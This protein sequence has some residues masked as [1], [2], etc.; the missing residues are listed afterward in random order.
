[1]KEFLL[2]GVQDYRLMSQAGV[3]QYVY[4]QK[5]THNA[6]WD[7]NISPEGKLYFALA[8]EICTNDYVRLCE[9]DYEHNTVK[10][11]GK[12]EDVILPSDRT[13]RASKFHSS[14]CF[15][16]DGRMTMT[17]HTTD[18]SPA[19][20]TWMPEAYYHHIWEGYPGSNIVVYDPRTGKAENYGV[21][22]PRETIYGSLYEPAHNC[23]YFTGMFRGHLYRYSFDTRKVQDLGRVSEQY[24]FRLTLGPD[25]NI[26]GASKTG[27]VYKVDTETLTVTD[28]N[29]K[30][31]HHAQAY[32]RDFTNLSIGRVG[33]DGKLYFAVMYGRR[34]VC[35]DT[36]TGEIRETEEYMPF[37]DKF[38]RGE[39]RHGIFGMDFDSQGVLWYVVSTLNDGSEHIE[40]GLPAGLFRW[41]ITR[42][43]TPEYMG[44]VGTK[45]RVASWNSEVCITKQDIMYII[46][47]N[48]G[49][50]GPDITAVDLKEY[51]PHM[52]ELGGNTDDGYY[53]PQDPHC[54]EM[55]EKLKALEQISAANP[56]VVPNAVAAAPA[57]LWRALAPDHIDDSVIKALVWQNADDL[58]GLCGGQNDYVFLLHK[59]AL[60][61]VIPADQADPALL[62]KLRAACDPVQA[63][64]A[65]VDLPFY[66]GRQYKAVPAA[67]ARLG[68]GRTVVG[69]VDG[70]LALVGQN[71][72]FALGPAANNGPIRS[73]SV[74][75]DGQTV[76]GVGGDESDLG[77]VFRYNDQTG[78]RWLGHA[79]ADREGFPGSFNLCLMSCCAVSPDGK[80]LAIG[81]GDRLGTVVLYEL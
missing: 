39:N 8:S 80:Y 37:A 44:I 26:Y 56:F 55:G 65:A 74:T 3:R 68:D 71:G 7:S 57:L 20:P 21:P 31:T 76:Y 22:V 49:T 9:Y 38:C 12:V 45:Q 61:N 19:H 1:M 10:E 63:P 78:L 34:L 77:V 27:Y 64:C 46:G 6:I 16:P 58:A 73:L 33:P 25:G 50:D 47:S 29:F 43:G 81:S 2:N 48:H 67:T 17:T 35:L 75:P 69:T 60:V 62:A 42:G 32:T 36:A 70:M 23:L 24:S 59:G 40:Y 18:K 54:I 13:I 14:I 11:C 66:P 4:P 30:P 53:D 5:C 72:V 15:M 41:D 52:Y 51:R 79:Q 28:L